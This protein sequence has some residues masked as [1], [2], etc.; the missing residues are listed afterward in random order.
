MRRTVLFICFIII[1]HVFLGQGMI[2]KCEGRDAAIIDI[3]NH[4]IKWFYI[5]NKPNMIK[6]YCK[7]KACAILGVEMISLSPSWESCTDSLLAYNSIVTQHLLDNY[8]FNFEERVDSFSAYF[9]KEVSCGIGLDSIEINSGLPSFMFTHNSAEI[10]AESFC[11][12]E[13]LL[14]RMITDELPKEQYVI[15]IVGHIAP[16]ENK[17]II[18]KRL[19][20]VETY[21]QTKIDNIIIASEA[22]IVS[23]PTYQYYKWRKVSLYILGK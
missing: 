10:K 19:A 17:D 22:S 18:K 2:D 21:L 16:N 1:A 8:G 11:L 13:G 14:S 4:K 23:S 5:Y 6:Q 3:K 20:T 15:K 12:F 9:E 7:H